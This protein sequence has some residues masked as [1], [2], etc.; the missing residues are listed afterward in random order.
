MQLAV[1]KVGAGAGGG[2]GSRVHTT[3]WKADCVAISWLYNTVQRLAAWGRGD[4][5]EA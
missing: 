1:F 2:A 3:L 5:T 4:V